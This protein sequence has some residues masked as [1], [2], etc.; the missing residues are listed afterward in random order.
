MEKAAEH[1]LPQDEYFFN[2]V[3]ED[4]FKDNLFEIWRDLKNIMGF[5]QKR[6]SERREEWL[7]DE[8]EGRLFFPQ[9]KQ[10]LTPIASPY[11]MTGI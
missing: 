11:G 5:P 6:P 7:Q 10:H 1:K 9:K 2:K 4:F 3:Y 8:G